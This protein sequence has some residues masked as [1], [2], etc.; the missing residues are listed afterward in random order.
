MRYVSKGW[1]KRTALDQ[2][3]VRSE[4]DQ[5]KQDQNGQDRHRIRVGRVSAGSEWMVR[6]GIEVNIN[7]VDMDSSGMEWDGQAGLIRHG[8]D[9][10]KPDQN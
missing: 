1:I 6:A 5:N 3:W 7:K 2:K 10:L 9:R 4:A 8:L